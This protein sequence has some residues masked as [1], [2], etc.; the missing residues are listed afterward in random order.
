MPKTIPDWTVF[1]IRLIVGGFF[2]YASIDKI[3]NPD[4]F[5]KVI[6]NYR[7]L[8]P[9]YINLMAIFSPWFEFTAGAGLIIGF[10]YRGANLLILGMLVVFIVAL[11]SAYAR[12]LN[13]N[14]GCFSTSNTLKSDLLWRAIEDIFLIAGCLL[15]MF[16]AKPFGRLSPSSPRLS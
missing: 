3:L 16:N 2:V 11:V 5:A 12:G 7:L 1:I 15:I 13:I 6:H 10:K 9:A 14:C 8:P 4:Q